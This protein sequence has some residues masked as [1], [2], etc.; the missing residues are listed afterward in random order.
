[1]ANDLEKRLEVYMRAVI[2]EELDK[3]LYGDIKEQAEKIVKDEI[4]AEVYSSYN[5]ETYDRT[6]SLINS[7]KASIR[8]TGSTRTLSIGHDESLLTHTSYDGSLVSEVPEWIQEGRVHAFGDSTLGYLS[9][10]PYFD[11]SEE[12]VKEMIFRILKK[13]MR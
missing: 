3:A 9:A 2:T 11:N 1:M 5:P 7:V 13:R 6:F 10:K 8:K 4:Q 12:K